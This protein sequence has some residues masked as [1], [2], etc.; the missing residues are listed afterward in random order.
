MKK[1][2][3]RGISKSNLKKFLLRYYGMNLVR[4]GNTWLIYKDRQ[5]VESFS[6]LREVVD[7]AKELEL[8]K[9]DTAEA[10]AEEGE[11]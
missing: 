2:N 9:A 1:N 11:K 6:T 4:K 5:H 8:K 7:W 10:P 3:G